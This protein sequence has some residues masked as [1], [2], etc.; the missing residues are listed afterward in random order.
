MCMT[1][2]SKASDRS[3]YSARAMAIS[4]WSRARSMQPAHGASSPEQKQSSV[5]AISRAYEYINSLKKEPCMDCGRAFPTACMD[6]DHRDPSKK[7]L[8]VSR[9][10]GYSLAKI[11][12]EIKKCDLVCS[13]CHRMRTHG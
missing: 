2:F 6:F 5:D 10:V 7:I 3:R 1:N 12:Q 4:G 13:N 9:M 8:P 11:R